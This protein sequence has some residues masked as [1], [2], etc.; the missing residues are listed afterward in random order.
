MKLSGFL[1]LF[2]LVTLAAS[3]AFGSKIGDF[4]S[5]DRLPK[6]NKHPKNF[7]ISIVIA[8]IE[9]VRII[10]LVIMLFIVFSPYNL[11]LGVVWTTCRIGE[12]LILIYNEI[13]YWRL[14]NIARQYLGTSGAEKNA[15][16]DLA[17]TI[18]QTRNSRWTL[19]MTLSGIGTFAYSILFV[20]YG[21]VPPI[22]GWL[23]IVVGILLV[24]DGGIKLV[25]SNFKVLSA[26]G[27]LL[28]I[29]FEA[30]IGVWLLF[31]SH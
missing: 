3:V 27:N 15:L 14:L 4:D 30:A 5:D 22:I 29:L 12:G 2:I 21:V 6:I 25:K 23:G 8:L 31:Y 9:Y 18:L 10:A 19:A 24:F 13:S 28:L 1:F 17:R 7:Q 11:I 16:S 26:I 20:V